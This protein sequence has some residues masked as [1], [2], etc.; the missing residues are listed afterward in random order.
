MSKVSVTQRLSR[1]VKGG[2]GG[3]S[4][5]LRVAYSRLERQKEEGRVWGETDRQTV[6]QTDRHRQSEGTETQAYS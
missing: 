6:R 2:G 5:L 4:I 1:L 3:E